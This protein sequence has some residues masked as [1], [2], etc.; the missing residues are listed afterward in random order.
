MAVAA[1]SP[2]DAILDR[3]LPIWPTPCRSNQE[4]SFHNW[5]STKPGRSQSQRQIMAQPV[6]VRR[7]Q[8]I[9]LRRHL[10]RLRRIPAL[11]QRIPGR[12]DGLALLLRRASD[13]TAK[14]G[15]GLQLCSPSAADRLALLWCCWRAA[16]ILICRRRRRMPMRP[17]R[18]SSVPLRLIARNTAP[19]LI[20]YR[21]SQRS[22]ADA[23][24]SGLPR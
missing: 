8:N 24:Q 22:I 20:P 12:G 2:H 3:S 17:S 10:L 7:H 13:T 16:W 1:A 21:C 14:L 15:L 6:R 18:R 23:R 19:W 11:A 9:L 5:V 4:L